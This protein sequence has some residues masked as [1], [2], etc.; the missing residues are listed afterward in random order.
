MLLTLRLAASAPVTAAVG[1]HEADGSI[2]AHSFEAIPKMR[3]YSIPL[4]NLR[5]AFR[6]E[7]ENGQLDAQQIDGI[8]L[9]VVTGGPGRQGRRS[10]DRLE[11]IPG[12]DLTIGIDYFGLVTGTG[13]DS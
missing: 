11:R 9:A 1:V 8:L 12:Q 3:E 4:S 13:P 6:T 10:A 5:S 7:D 2:Y